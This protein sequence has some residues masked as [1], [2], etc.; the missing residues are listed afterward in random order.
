MEEAILQPGNP[1]CAWPRMLGDAGLDW[2]M[3]KFDDRDV[4]FLTE[5]LCG[6]GDVVGRT[7]A[8]CFCPLKSKHFVFRTLWPRRLHP[9]AG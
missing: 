7:T 1:I 5:L 8:E 9:T 3:P 4:V 6:G 2:S